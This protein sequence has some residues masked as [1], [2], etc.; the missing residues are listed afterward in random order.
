M[1]ICFHLSLFHKFGHSIRI[2]SKY[3][4]GPWGCGDHREDS[5]GE[6]S[7]GCADT[8]SDRMWEWGEWD[9]EQCR[10]GEVASR[11]SECLIWINPD[12][13][14]SRGKRSLRVRSAVHMPHSCQWLSS[15]ATLGVNA[16]IL[17]ESLKFGYD[18]F[19]DVTR[20]RSLSRRSGDLL[21]HNSE[22]QHQAIHIFTISATVT[23]IGHEILGLGAGQPDRRTL[24]GLKRT[25][26][27]M[28]MSY[29]ERGFLIP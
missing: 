20:F 13:E 29:C 12:A 19:T 16:E 6:R 28:S 17:I 7:E 10:W 4:R 9:Y 15:N 21:N 3:T 14:R 11:N 25:W 1:P 26:C 2:K 5:K 23:A 8:A 22:S 24:V 18:F 27:I